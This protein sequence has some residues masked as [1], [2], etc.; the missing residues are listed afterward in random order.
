M[1]PTSTKSYHSP[2]KPFTRPRGHTHDYYKREESHKRHQKSPLSSVRKTVPSRKIHSSRKSGSSAQP[3]TRSLGERAHGLS[4]GTSRLP[5][6]LSSAKLALVKEYQEHLK[7]IQSFIASP[8]ELTREEA[9]QMRQK[10]DRIMTLRCFSLEKKF[11][12][13][14]SKAK[15][16]LR[17][18]LSDNI[19]SEQ[20]M[21][22]IESYLH[23][24]GKI[25]EIKR[26]CE[27]ILR[28]ARFTKVEQASH[29]FHLC[30]RCYLSKEECSLLTK[31]LQEEGQQNP[32][33]W[34][35]DRW[36]QHMSAFQENNNQCNSSQLLT[37]FVLLFTL[38]WRDSSPSAFGT[39]LEGEVGS[40]LAKTATQLGAVIS[41]WNLPCWAK[42]REKLIQQQHDFLQACVNGKIHG[43]DMDQAY[44][45]IMYLIAQVH[46][47]G[48]TGWLQSVWGI[49]HDYFRRLGKNNPLD[50]QLDTIKNGVR[51]T[52]PSELRQQIDNFRRTFPHCTYGVELLL[53]HAE[54]I[55]HSRAYEIA[56]DYQERQ[57]HKK[58]ALF[59][60]KNTASQK[61]GI[62]VVQDR[63]RVLIQFGDVDRAWTLYQQQAEKTEENS[64]RPDATRKRKASA[65]SP[66]PPVEPPGKRHPGVHQGVLDDEQLVLLKS[67][68]EVLSAD[69]APSP[70]AMRN[71]FFDIIRKH[72]GERV[73]NIFKKPDMSADHLTGQEIE[74][75]KAILYSI[76]TK[77]HLPEPLFNAY[78][79]LKKSTPGP[80]LLIHI[81]FIAL[82]NQQNR[83]EEAVATARQLLSHGATFAGLSTE[84]AKTE[85]T[86]LCVQY[87][88]AAENVYPLPDVIGLFNSLLEKEDVHAAE[89]YKVV[90]ICYWHH[91]I[92]Q[93]EELDEL[94]EDQ[95]LPPGVCQSIQ[96]ALNNTFRYAELTGQDPFFNE[97]K[98]HIAEL[99]ERTTFLAN[100]QIAPEWKPSRKARDYFDR[101][102][103][104]PTSF[105]DTRLSFQQHAS[106]YSSSRFS[107]A[108]KH[109]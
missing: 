76:K 73:Y 104:K 59:L 93:L 11:R 89:L 10:L 88:L 46:E 78:Y 51:T 25:T 3:R 6:A 48:N 13:D 37:S 71:R 99:S 40:R 57:Y 28:T 90:A 8:W 52:A 20:Q 29:F 68:L 60:A 86:K 43:A 75:I 81:S 22:V 69:T 26:C 24:L 94:D 4:K 15:A 85:R 50:I 54:M 16:I 58:H 105:G 63:I 32:E 64:K 97:I 30:K 70:E 5:P 34:L 61:S 100:K 66:E 91:A 67:G 33:Q 36:Y 79:C 14:L 103:T 18:L 101:A 39:K 107:R 80:P 35:T 74:S 41:S 72:A 102:H 62:I 55:Y 77:E 49:Y 83:F 109:D 106:L 12:N 56:K 44:R 92:I 53:R 1:S 17:Y 84:E 45:R 31:E 2:G 98:G 42:E 9:G 108:F 19:D 23:P 95:P 7:E 87:L 47:S 27:E 65:R 82:M 96:D 38:S 21:N